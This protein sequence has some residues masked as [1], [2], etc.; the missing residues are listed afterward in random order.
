M[1]WIVKDY[2]TE[3]S[4]DNMVAVKYEINARTTEKLRVY[5]IWI[6]LKEQSDD[7]QL[8]YDASNVPYEEY[9]K[10]AQKKV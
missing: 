7:W 1:S 4:N 5:G 9:I 6:M 2:I 10:N 3:Y 8:V